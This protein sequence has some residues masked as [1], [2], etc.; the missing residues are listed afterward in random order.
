MN[1][2]DA[3]HCCFRK[4]RHTCFLSAF[5][6]ISSHARPT[7]HFLGAADALPTPVNQTC[8]GKLSST[9]AEQLEAAGAHAR[10]LSYLQA[11]AS[12]RPAALPRAPQ[13]LFSTTGLSGTFQHPRMLASLPKQRLQMALLCLRW[14]LLKLQLS[15]GK[16]IQFCLDINSVP[17][18][19]NS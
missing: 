9:K 3:G 16:Y 6:L 8:R 4:P 17:R 5:S 19:R 18:V 13:P 14:V 7:N 12:C 10:K 2:T 1:A 11:N 15:A